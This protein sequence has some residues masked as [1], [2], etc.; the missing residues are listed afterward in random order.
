[1]YVTEVRTTN[2]GPQIFV[3]RAHPGLV[4]KLFEQEVPELREGIVVIE[5]IAREPG[6]RTKIAVYSRD[7][8]VDPVGA[9]VGP[10]GSRALGRCSR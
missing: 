3:S 10:K 7:R 9:C 2:R 8:N 1:V 6:S 5:N 4:R